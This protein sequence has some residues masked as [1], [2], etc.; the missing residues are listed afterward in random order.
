MPHILS[1][2]V[3]QYKKNKVTIIINIIKTSTKIKVS[4]WFEAWT[5]E[6]GQ[7]LQAGVSFFLPL[8][9]PCAGKVTRANCFSK[10]WEA[11]L[12][13]GASVTL[14]EE[15]PFRIFCSLPCSCW[16]VEGGCW[17]GASLTDW[18]A[19]RAISVW[20]RICKAGGK[21]ILSGFL[22]SEE[23]STLA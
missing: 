4:A 8:R 20:L 3:L 9:D 12:G 5:L 17:R 16:L 23:A 18:G 1:K 11:I 2:F 10:P 6:P 15:G 14:S 22:S 13:W 21:M 19:R 7:Q